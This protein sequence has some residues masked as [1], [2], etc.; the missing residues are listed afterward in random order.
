MP[1]PFAPALP[2]ALLFL[3]APASGTKAEMC[4]NSEPLPAALP[5][6]RMPL[7]MRAVGAYRE[8]SRA[9]LTT[10]KAVELAL[11]PTPKVAYFVRPEK[12]GGSSSYGGLVRFTVQQA[13]RW[14][15]ALGSGAWVDV[16]KDGAA[17]T[18]VAHGHG[19]RCSGVRKMVDYDLSAGTYL[20]QVAA[21]DTDS[22]S[23]LVTRL[24]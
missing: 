1:L 10:G 6:W 12:P 19:P 13:G 22:V 9:R 11:L 21:N 3:A 15:V 17:M 24:P 8:V 23:L 14:R 18:S 2:A 7:P 4:A 20:L 16:V 5:A